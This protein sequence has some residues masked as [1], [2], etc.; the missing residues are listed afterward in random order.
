MPLDDL[1]MGTTLLWHNSRSSIIVV[2]HCCQS[3]VLTVGTKLDVVQ[4]KCRV[5]LEKDRPSSLGGW[6]TQGVWWVTEEAATL[7]PSQPHL[8]HNPHHAHHDLW[9]KLPLMQSGALWT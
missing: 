6:N 3:Q 5:E 1:M 7:S 4:Y 8:S 9:D 2:L